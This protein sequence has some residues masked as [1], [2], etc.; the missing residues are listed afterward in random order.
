MY[1]RLI[2]CL[3]LIFLNFA[4]YGTAPAR[5]DFRALQAFIGPDKNASFAEQACLAERFCALGGPLALSEECDSKL[6]NCLG[7]LA[8]AGSIDGIE[9]SSVTGNCI[10]ALRNMSTPQRSLLAAP[11][12]C[13]GA[14]PAL[15]TKPA[16]TVSEAQCI[17]DR[18]TCK[19]TNPFTGETPVQCRQKYRSCTRD[20]SSLPVGDRQN[21]RSIRS[22]LSSPS[23]KSY[24]YCIRQ[25]PPPFAAA[26]ADKT[27]RQLQG[28][29][30]LLARQKGDA[31]K[32]R[33]AC[34]AEKIASLNES[35]TH[36]R[37][38]DGF[39]M[40]LCLEEF[41][42]LGPLA[43]G[44]GGCTGCLSELT[45]KQQSLLSNP[46][47]CGALA[48]IPKESPRTATDPPPRT[49]QEQ[50]ERIEKDAPPPQDEF[51]LGD[52]DDF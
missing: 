47:G 34:L 33:V 19:Q 27:A 16:M 26:D 3:F 38:C 50:V 22:Y 46:K 17:T 10:F 51:D 36:K 30:Q 40:T 37:S 1:N 15:A 9:A 31:R 32:T 24:D 43:Y 23:L 13:S 6:R 45:H 42:E 49:W 39:A 2:F 18:K 20:M 4:A 35:I 25:I 12:G 8:S 48:S 5:D 28:L 21:C 11:Q 29:N 52:F 7:W 44:G 41:V 14:P